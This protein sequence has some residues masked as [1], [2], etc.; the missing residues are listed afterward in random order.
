MDYPQFQKDL[1]TA[2]ESE[3]LGELLFQ[4]AAKHSRSKAQQYK[5]QILARLETQTLQKLQQFLLEHQQTAS[6]RG[7][8]RLQAKASGIAM[9]KMPWKVA[10]HLLKQGTKPFLH[11]FE[12]MN[13]HSNLASQEF[14]QYLLAHEQALATF[15]THELNGNS[16]HSLEPIFKLLK[17]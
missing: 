1:N 10:M 15:A 14:L 5:W 3:I 11:T 6:I 9:A 12:R 8:I 16:K 2:L 17:S 4:Y 7:Y 13:R